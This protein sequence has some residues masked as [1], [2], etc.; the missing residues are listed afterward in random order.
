[1]RQRHRSLDRTEIRFHTVKVEHQT[2][3]GRLLLNKE[4]GDFGCHR[5]MPLC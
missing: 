1:M 2:R 3:R 5:T 4:A